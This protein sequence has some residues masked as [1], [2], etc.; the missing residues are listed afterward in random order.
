MPTKITLCTFCLLTNAQRPCL[1]QE[2]FFRG[3]LPLSSQSQH[4][5]P[6]LPGVL[7]QRCPTLGPASRLI[8]A[9]WPRVVSLP[10]HCA[11]G[12]GKH[13]NKIPKLWGDLTFEWPLAWPNAGHSHQQICLSRDLEPANPKAPGCLPALRPPGVGCQ[14]PLGTLNKM[15]VLFLVPSTRP[16]TRQVTMILAEKLQ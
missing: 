9:P 10:M 12:E 6:A 15:W 13:T 7:P 8:P 5:D 2:L 4:Q 14:P 16:H 3:P 11:F 1:P